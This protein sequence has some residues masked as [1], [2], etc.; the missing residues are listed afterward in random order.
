MTNIVFESG[1]FSKERKTNITKRLTGRCLVL[2]LCAVLALGLFTTAAFADEKTITGLGTGAISNP[3]EGAGGWSKVYFGSKGRPIRFNV[4]TTNTGDFGGT[5]MLLDC[6]SILQ[7]MKF[8]NDG[9]PNAGAQKANEWA[10]SDIRTW[11]NGDF[12]T[13]RF[14]TVEA[15]AIAESTR[16]GRHP[17]MNC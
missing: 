4:L 11:L 12:L 2:L 5:T 15:S 3:A 13:G 14:T 8:D 9:S 16:A 6:A 17:I 10:Y 7:Y 1:P